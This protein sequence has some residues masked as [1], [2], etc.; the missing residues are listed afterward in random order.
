MRRV[1][2]LYLPRW[3]TD[4]WRRKHG[5]GSPPDKPLVMAMRHGQQRLVSSVDEAAARAG[6]PASPS[7]MPRRMKT[8]RR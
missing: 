8:G 5:G 1:V 3:P 2:S 7:R 6:W 4:R